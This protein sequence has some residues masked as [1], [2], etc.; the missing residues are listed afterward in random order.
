MYGNH[1][2]P[3]T[4]G[5]GEPIG[6]RVARYSKPPFGSLFWASEISP[7]E[8]RSLASL[9]VSWG[10]RRCVAERGAGEVNASLAWGGGI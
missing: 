7:F 10:S 3:L 8:K 1:G 5:A 2:L 9:A 6:R 4:F